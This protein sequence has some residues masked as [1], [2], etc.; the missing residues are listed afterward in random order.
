MD[1]MQRL[2]P[3]DLR[4]EMRVPGEICEFMETRKTPER[5][6]LVQPPFV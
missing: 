4:R 5:T 3:V 2:A 6:D 1:E